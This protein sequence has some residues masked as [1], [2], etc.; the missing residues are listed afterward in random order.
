MLNNVFMQGKMGMAV[1]LPP[2]VGMITEQAPDL[3]YSIAP[4]PTKDGEKVTLG[5]ADH[6]MAFKNDGS[7][8]KEVGAFLDFF[9]QAENYVK[10]V[11]TEGFLPTTKNGATGTT[12]TE[13]A[14]FNELL[15]TAKFYPSINP[16]WGATQGLIQQQIG[17]IAQGK[18][19]AEVLKT[20]QE[21]SAT[22]L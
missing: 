21:S 7:K 19:P 11:D 18:A 13:F 6:L 12:K 2:I 8:S 17:T 9:Y 4:F 5:V 22:G 10:F 16:A 20:I 14:P 15:P 1:G 3:K